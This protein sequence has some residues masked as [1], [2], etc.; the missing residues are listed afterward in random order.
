M[1]S[2]Y[3]VAFADALVQP[4]QHFGFVGQNQVEMEKI[5]QNICFW[6]II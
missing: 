2:N 4:R 1:W 5:N 3:R 6:Y